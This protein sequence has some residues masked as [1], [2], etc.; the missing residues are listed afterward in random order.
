MKNLKV[1]KIITFG[2]FDLFHIG[3]KN[4]IDKCNMISS[5]VVIGVS[6]DKLNMKKNKQSYDSLSDRIYNVKKYSKS[7]IVFE[8]ESLEQKLDYIKYYNCNVLVMGDDW[9][10]SF[11]SNEYECIYFKR[12]NNISS[13]LLRNRLN[14]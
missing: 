3:H 5:N 9:N 1:T 2:T 12:T 6:T 8:E 7:K 11:N 13:T 4:I 10:N 14:K